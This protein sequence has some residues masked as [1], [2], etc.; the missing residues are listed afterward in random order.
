MARPSPTTRLEHAAPILPVA[1]MARS[2]EYYTSCLGFTNAAWGSEW[3]TCV[4]RDGAALYLCRQGQGH[5]GTW[6]WIGVEDAAALHDEY[7]ASGAKVRHAPRNYEW[8]LE[9]H[10]EDLDGNVLRFGSEPA[11]GRPFES[12]EA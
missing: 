8:A 2:V 12:F 9:F 1:N 3:F 5:P 4:T 6:A 7:Q 11:A 10:V